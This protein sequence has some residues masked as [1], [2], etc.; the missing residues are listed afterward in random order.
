M[1]TSDDVIETRKRLGWT[2][3]QLADALGVAQR[4]VR[5]WE[6]GDREAPD[7]LKHA[8]WWLLDTYG[9]STRGIGT[10]DRPKERKVS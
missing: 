1:T 8:L 9:G 6:G 7:Y 4:T 2:Q 10:T 5:Y 3:Q